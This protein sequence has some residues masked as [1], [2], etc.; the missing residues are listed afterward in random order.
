MIA[1]LRRLGRRRMVLLVVAAIAM[2]AAAAVLIPALMEFEEAGFDGL[3]E[4]LAIAYGAIL[5]VLV[6]VVVL[7]QRPGQGVG[8]LSLAIG[9]AFAVSILARIMPGPQQL[10]DIG[11]G[12]STALAG[13][14]WFVGG[15]LLVVRFP[16]G[17]R[18]SRLGASLEL[19]LVVAIIGTAIASSKE[20]V[21]PSG[22]LASLYDIANAVG[23]AGL[24]LV[25]LGA[26]VD[27]GLRYRKTDDLRRTQMRWVLA[28]EGLIPLAILA[29]V[30]FGR[31]DQLPWLFAVMLLSFGLPILAIAIAITRYHLYD[32][33]RI[34]SSS[35]SYVVVSA[36]LIGVFVALV[37][38]MQGIVSGVVASPGS[39]L[40]PRVVAISTL[41]VA[42]LFNPV[43]RRVQAA[44]DRRFHR[45]SYD[46]TRI[47]AGFSGRLRDQLDLLT[48]S[49]ELRATTV[50][51][52]EP[53][54]TGVW[55]RARSARR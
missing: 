26:V 50:R 20:G 3:F 55:L 15:S 32:I 22:V 30:A 33:D 31:D 54:S 23:F 45:A 19:I 53:A 6:G 35:I 52:L 29:F 48:V 25:Y 13:L 5:Y 11:Q 9:L 46:A 38:M 34:V 40:D 49:G 41:I 18:T 8:R 10:T 14:G 42:A 24:V 39:E 12:L 2:I 4:P 36:M 16:D 51:A 21:R 47:V 37:L 17:Q 28:A 7:W 1:G 27:L 44:V 43:R